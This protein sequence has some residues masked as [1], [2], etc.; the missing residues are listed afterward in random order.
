MLAWTFS[1][2]TP[3]EVAALLRALGQHR[4]VREIDHRIHWAIDAA[5]AQ[6]PRFLPHAAGH[7]ARRE[8]EPN[9]DLLSRDPSLWRPASIDDVIA[10]LTAFW[11]PGF[12]G[13]LARAQLHSILEA[14]DFD[15]PEHEP[16][17]SDADNPPHPE[18][19]ELNWVLHP[20][21]E[22]DAERHAGALQAMEEAGE[23]VD[24]SAPVYQEGP[25]LS[26]VE[27]LEGAE[28]GVLASEFYV[29]SDGPVSYADYVFRG[30]SKM[31][32][33]VDPPEAG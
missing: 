25:C 5:L 19:I 20:I 6:D 14:A 29:W 13:I 8:R 28:N 33:L 15:L 32:K 23:E 1:A 27:L 3:D 21:D 26:A 2:K 9:L 18:L 16:F 24:V 22:L 7:M 12:A 4:Y 31:A 17:D 10:A 30:A 11:D